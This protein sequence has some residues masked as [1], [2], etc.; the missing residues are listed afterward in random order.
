MEGIHRVAFIASA[1]ASASATRRVLAAEDPASSSASPDGRSVHL[2]SANTPG[3][4]SLGASMVEC[5]RL[6][7]GRTIPHI[8]DSQ[9]V[10]RGCRVVVL[11]GPIDDRRMEAAPPTTCSRGRAVG[12]ARCR[13][14]ASC[15]GPWRSS[16]TCTPSSPAV[17]KSASSSIC[18]AVHRCAAGWYVQPGG[19][20][21]LVMDPS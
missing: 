6:L 10:F 14:C 1:V 11:R 17:T 8:R 4:S 15:A 20:I 5:A 21:G 13:P 19:Y 12:R 16:P 7:I 18:V 2:T 9:L 3:G